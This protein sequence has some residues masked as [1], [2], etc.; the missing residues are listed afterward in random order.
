MDRTKFRS[1]RRP[2]QHGAAAL[3]MNRFAQITHSLVIIE[4]Y[5]RIGCNS[6]GA[7]RQDDQRIDV[8][9]REARGFAFGKA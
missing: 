4:S 8:E 6:A 5:Q 2:L 9:L 1:F 7:A 3:D